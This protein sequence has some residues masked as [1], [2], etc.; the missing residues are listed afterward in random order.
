MFKAKLVAM[1]SHCVPFPDVEIP[2]IIIFMASIPAE[3]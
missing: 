2:E 3:A 1:S